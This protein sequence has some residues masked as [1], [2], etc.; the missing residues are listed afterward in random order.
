MHDLDRVALESSAEW[1]EGELP[2]NGGRHP[3][4]L[5]DVQTDEELDQVLGDVIRTVS[6]RAGRAIPRQLRPPLM[7]YLK[8]AA[9][10]ALPRLGASVGRFPGS[11]LRDAR[12]GA[13]IGRQIARAL[14]AREAGQA[15][16]DGSD[17][18]EA[19]HRVIDL[20]ER[21]AREA[22]RVH[23]DAP[24]SSA[25]AVARRAAARLASG[26]ARPDGVAADS[27]RSGTWT[28]HGRTITLRI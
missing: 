18:R 26:R 19:A 23:P 7:R 4:G 17:D 10:T 27:R 28:Q 1:N 9:V 5:L 21:V 2:G 20:A 6:K 11:D 14:P 13:K 24:S 3:E 15:S 16:P 25:A 22:A 8:G 12:A